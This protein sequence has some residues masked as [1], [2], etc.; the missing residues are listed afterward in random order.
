MYPTPAPRAVPLV[1]G[2]PPKASHSEGSARGSSDTRSPAPRGPVTHPITTHTAWDVRLCCAAR[3]QDP[4]LSALSAVYGS[5]IQ[6]PRH[7]YTCSSERAVKYPQYRDKQQSL[8]NFLDENCWRLCLGK[9]QCTV[10]ASPAYAGPSG[11]ELQTTSKCQKD[12]CVQSWQ[13][14]PYTPC[15]LFLEVKKKARIFLLS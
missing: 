7:N 12:F 9:S 6:Q 14:F 4:Q 15:C 1:H 11:R 10:A 13:H 2:M 3:E 5:L 8:S